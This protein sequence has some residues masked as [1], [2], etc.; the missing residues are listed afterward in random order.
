VYGHLARFTPEIEEYVISRQYE[1]KSYL[2][3][4]FPP[5]DK[6][7]VTQ[8]QIIAW[9]GNLGSSEGPHLH[10]EIRKSESEVPVNPL[11]FDFGPADNISPIIE[12]LVIYPVNRHTFINGQNSSRRFDV[13]G[14]NGK[15]HLASGNE[16]KISGAAGFGIKS[17]DLM[18]ESN[19]KCGVYSIELAIDNSTVFK[20][21][22]NS[23]SFNESRY[24]N[25]HVDYETYLRDKIFI[26]RLYLLPNDKLSI[27]SDLENRGICLFNDN[28]DHSALITVTDA[29]KNTSTLAFRIR[30]VPATGNEKEHAENRNLKMMP[31]NRSNKF[32]AKNISVTIPS[33]ALYDT[34]Y[35]SY[36]STP[37]GWDMYSPLHF[38]HNRF[39][40][41][42]KAYTL[43][44]RPERIPAG[45][46]SKMLIIELGEEQKRNALYTT[47]SDGNLVAEPMSFGRFY[48]GIDT[49]AP[50]ISANGLLQGANLTG[51]SEI[52]IRITDD[53]SGIK[54]YDPTI[55]GNWALFEYDQKNNI[56]I[57][58]FDSKRITQGKKHMISLK[59]TDNKDNSSYFNCDF[60]W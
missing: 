56:L 10:Y 35:F 30:S 54:S 24:I 7:P 16:I 43:S 52:R 34:L 42:H 47:W 14:T 53:L 48:A 57:Y 38:V 45:K 18:N 3:T 13:A 23:F 17:F 58:R 12:K 2:V 28:K 25:S 5:R 60:R 31:Y 20:Y 39:T 32:E 1:N 22:M 29:Y 8:G 51:K 44:I 36:K 15:Y 40:P 27:Y 9:S 21:V 37:A 46:E 49:V 4:L 6:F 41:V 59:V 50:L 26:E 19:N 55:D 11:L 33:G